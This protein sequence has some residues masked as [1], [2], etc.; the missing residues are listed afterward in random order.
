MPSLKTPPLPDLGAARVQVV[1]ACVERPLGDAALVALPLG[2][3]SEAVRRRHPLVF[4]AAYRPDGGPCEAVLWL[5]PRERKKGWHVHVLLRAAKGRRRLTEASL[6]PVRRDGTQSEGLVRR[7]PSRAMG[8]LL[9]RVG[10]ALGAGEVGVW[11]D[12][13]FALP[14]SRYSPVVKVPAELVGPREDAPG[15]DLRGVRLVWRD[16][17]RRVIIDAGE[18]DATVFRVSLAAHTKLV[19]GA[20]WV[21]TMMGALRDY[22][23]DIAPSASLED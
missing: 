20:G 15:V 6:L 16:N 9:A 12:A 11:L 19:L 5:D 18:D 8:R 14:R 17:S 13:E 3:E 10:Q 21:D 1:Q 7:L 22:L 4:H 23:A 2:R